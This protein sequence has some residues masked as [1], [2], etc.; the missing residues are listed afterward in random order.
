MVT[1][2]RASSLALIVAACTFIG[3]NSCLASPRTGPSTQAPAKVSI[4]MMS[5]LDRGEISHTRERIDNHNYHVGRVVVN[6]PPEQVWAALT[7]YSKHVKAIP[8]LKKLKVLSSNQNKKK[9][10]FEVAS[11]GGLWKFDYILNITEVAPNRIEWNRESGA[12][13]ANEGFW[14]LDS[15][16]GG[17]RTLVTYAK[18]IDGGLMLPQVFVDGQLKKTM[19]DVLANMRA[20]I[21]GGQQIAEKP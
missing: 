9:I 3:S 13:K 21:Q 7:D 2:R 10:W 14:Q 5:S 11:L 16:A 1:L 17:K 6:S 12:F 15:V 18:F 8:E 4:A 20:E 19:P